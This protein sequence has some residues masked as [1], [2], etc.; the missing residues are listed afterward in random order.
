MWMHVCICIHISYRSRAQ[1]NE[2]TP[3]PPFLLKLTWVLVSRNL[4]K[5]VDYFF[6]GDNLEFSDVAF[7]WHVT[8][9][10]MGTV[11]EL[12]A[13]LILLGVV[14]RDVSSEARENTWRMLSIPASFILPFTQYSRTSPTFGFGLQ[15]FRS[16]YECDQRQNWW[17]CMA[18]QKFGYFVR[19]W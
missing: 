3:P 13:F 10:F 19:N 9:L 16:S 5:P 8:N 6:E 18:F 2:E 17:P 14:H 7:S 11:Y 15:V 4:N 1:M 12:E